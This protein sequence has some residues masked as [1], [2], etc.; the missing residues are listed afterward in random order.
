MNKQLLKEIQKLKYLNSYDRGKTLNENK[1]LTEQIGPAVIKAILGNVVE[2]GL[3]Q[4][5]K[6]NL[7]NLPEIFGKELVQEVDDLITKAVS[8]G[9]LASTLGKFNGQEISLKLALFKNWVTKGSTELMSPLE[10]KIFYEAIA[11]VDESFN[12]TLLAELAETAEGKLLKGGTVSEEAFQKMLKNTNSSLYGFSETYLKQISKLSGSIVD[13]V[14]KQLK[15]ATDKLGIAADRFGKFLQKSWKKSGTW[16]AGTGLF[17]SGPEISSKI[18]TYIVEKHLAKLAKYEVGNIPSVLTRLGLPSESIQQVIKAI[19]Q[20]TAV[21]SKV[22]EEI[23]TILVS[24]ATPELEK[25][26][27]TIYKDLTKSKW[28]KKDIKNYLDNAFIK[29]GENLQEKQIKELKK[30]LGL[31]A[32]ASDELAIMLMKEIQQGSGVVKFLRKVWYKPGT[33]DQR[34][35]HWIT[36]KGGSWK[37]WGRGICIAFKL[38]LFTSLTPFINEYASL[39]AL[40]GLFTDSSK[41]SD[42][43]DSLKDILDPQAAAIAKLNEPTRRQFLQPE[44]ETKSKEEINAYYDGVAEA[45][46]IELMTFVTTEAETG[47][48]IF[49]P[50]YRENPEE[51]APEKKIDTNSVYG[52]NTGNGRWYTGPFLNE[53]N[54]ATDN[55][56]F[57]FVLASF[58]SDW[59]NIDEAQIANLITGRPSRFGIA[60][61]AERYKHHS[62]RSLWGDLDQLEMG[63]G[64]LQNFVNNFL[65]VDDIDKHNLGLASILRL[66]EYTRNDMPGEDNIIMDPKAFIWDDWWEFPEVLYDQI[67]TEGK[68]EE[69]EFDPEYKGY[70]P[71]DLMTKFQLEPEFT[72]ES[73]DGNNKYTFKIETEEDLYKIPAKAF[74]DFL[75]NEAL[76]PFKQ[77]M[78]HHQYIYEQK[79]VGYDANG[80][81]MIQWDRKRNPAWIGTPKDTGIKEIVE[82]QWEKFEERLEKGEINPAANTNDTD[83]G[84]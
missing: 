50:W 10:K 55:E 34:F 25:I 54:K 28:F 27:N 80:A 45:I 53:L 33:K 39:K 79:V 5:I 16:I 71:L 2:F 3:E 36:C 29:G 23:Y 60:K 82:Q 43:L 48:N 63:H 47:S 62:G 59:N 66:P 84:S 14:S 51:E 81:E 19:Q 7:R 31:P 32:E 37:G 56:V 73:L 68:I 72:I 24:R 83:G 13:G 35:I 40:W 11:S 8:K 64:V 30:L 41:D 21:P 61:V 22:M 77:K 20:K 9:R 38:H 17:K 57:Q 65:F 26:F 1:I 12:K 70:M 6:L 44:Q 15:Q 58:S 49:P 76:S 46:G 4:A 74:N 69:V 18:R 52:P 42:T 67:E 78:Y 75:E